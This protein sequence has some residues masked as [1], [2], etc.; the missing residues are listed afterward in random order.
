[1]RFTIV[2]IMARHRHVKYSLYINSEYDAQ[3]ADSVAEV[4]IQSG[5]NRTRTFGFWLNRESAIQLRDTL[6]R[7]LYPGEANDG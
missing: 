2:P 1:M 5:A 7:I 4:I 6:N 3:V